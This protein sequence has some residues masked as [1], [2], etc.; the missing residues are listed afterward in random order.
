MFAKQ[1]FTGVGIV[2]GLAGL[3]WAGTPRVH[4]DDEHGDDFQIEQG[5]RIAP[6]HLTYDKHNRKLVGLGSYIVNA[7]SECNGC[8]SAG[9]ATAYAVDATGASHNPYLRRGIF[10][11]PK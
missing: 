9:P 6:V 11:P 8:H 2:A 10:T 5:L 7:V 4:A 1:L 3:I